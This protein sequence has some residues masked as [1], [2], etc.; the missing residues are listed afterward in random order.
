MTTTATA[1]LR[2][3]GTCNSASR[4]TFG[5]ACAKVVRFWDAEPKTAPSGRAYNNTRCPECGDMVDGTPVKVTHSATVVCDAKCYN[6]VSAGCA[7]SCDGENHGK[8][9]EGRGVLI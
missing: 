6:A 3:R 5:K 9:H 8:A 4:R 2:F 1:T 7:C